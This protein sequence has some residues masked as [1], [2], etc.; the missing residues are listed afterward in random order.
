VDAGRYYLEGDLSTPLDVDY[1]VVDVANGAKEAT[2]SCNAQRVGSGLRNAKFS[3]LKEDGT[4]LGAN[5]ST[6]EIATKDSDGVKVTLPA[7]TTKV[8]IKV[9]TGSQDPIVSG[10]YYRCGVNVAAP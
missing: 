1:F 5:N 3:L 9:E 6:T 4:P 8:V 7:N 2:L 10:A